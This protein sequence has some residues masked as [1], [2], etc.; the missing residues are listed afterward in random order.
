M[1]N[2]IT[3]VPPDKIGECHNWREWFSRIYL[4]L[5]GSVAGSVPISHNALTGLQGGLANEEYHLS[6]AEHTG[7]TGLGDTTLHYH[8]S[9]RAL[10]NATGILAIA[11]GGTGS[12]T[13][14]TWNQDTTGKSAATDALNSA[15]T[16]VNVAAATAPTVGQVLT[17]V[18]STH[19]TWQTFSGSGISLAAARQVTSLRI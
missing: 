17:A 15:T 12:A 4:L 16:V 14:P 8:S 5:N 2:N 18:D 1:A 19:A 3:P 13:I 11:N 9:D 7:L 6:N 10:A